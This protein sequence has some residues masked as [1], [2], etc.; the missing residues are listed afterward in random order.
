M[1][2]VHCW[3][4]HPVRRID[5]PF[6]YQSDF[7]LECGMR[8]QI[9]FNNRIVT[10]FV[11][12]IDET[13]ETDEEVTERLGF[14]PK[15]ID[16]VLDQE[17]LITPEL[18][19][20]AMWMRETTLSTAISCFQAMLPSKVKPVS[21]GSRAV[22][23]KWVRLTDAEV[24]LTPKQLEAYLYVKDNQPLKYSLLRKKY[25]N[26]ARALAEKNAVEVF[27]K[28]REAESRE[29]KYCESP[30]IL[31]QEQQKA[32][33]EIRSSDDPVFLV[34]GVTGSGKTELYLRLAADVL[35]EGAQVLILVPEISLTPQMIRRVSERFGADLAIYHSGLNAQEKYEQYRKV[36][37]GRASVVVGTRSAVFLP[38]Q[39]LGLIVM[40]E[41]HDS[42]Y[43]QEN[44]PAYH[45][46]DIAVWRGAWHH[47]PVILGSATP[48][49]ESYA[50]AV[51]NVYHLITL[52]SRINQT[53]PE[54]TVIP[55][56]E[57]MKKGQSYI[58]S[59]PL[60]D[61][62][63]SRLEA[64]RQVILLLNRRGYSNML[65]C[66]SCQE[67]V[68]CPHCDI[69]MSYHHDEKVMKCH[70]C[71][72]TMPVP[73]ICPGCGQKAGFTSYGYGTQKLEMELQK[74]FP[75]AKLLRMDADTTSRK[76]A[77]E[78][79]LSD[80]GEGR[81]DILLGTQMIAKGLDYPNVTLV[82]ILNGDE[83]LSRTDYRSC[84]M[85]FDLLM[86]ATGRSGRAKEAGEVVYQVFD[87]GHYAVQCA[88]NNDYRTFFAKEMQFRHAGM[89]PPYTYMIALTVSG[90]AQKEVLKTALWLRNNLTGNYKTIGIIELLKIQDRFRSRIILKGQHLDEMRSDIRKL[91]DTDEYKKAGDIR[92]D[93]NPMTLD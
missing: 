27:E 54:V 70:T 22:Q 87:P 64:H 86:Q 69:A 73:R 9:D 4:E 29:G 42:S 28:E 21:S 41:E 75:E 33:D 36:K 63:R 48:S 47:C 71:G 76:N 20:L 67:A 61:K 3:I 25:P 12:D 26:Q 84:E 90:A 72:T 2:L 79:I 5:Q 17:S 88:V 8:V 66:R 39:K 51:K 57:S 56:R 53:L 93:V 85:T 6:T 60:R 24:S 74:M 82:G 78:K 83:G 16:A 1:K 55:L 31:N 65:R 7:S 11:E 40:D 32:Y 18:H 30:F 91:F 14:T 43:K 19:E 45:C 38:F 35:N 50:R 37:T 23:E 68:V 52:N 59:D 89:Y 13:D 80:F 77:H 46:R 34:H 15:K 44:Q 92:I 81:A 49:L 10:G 62:I 58:I